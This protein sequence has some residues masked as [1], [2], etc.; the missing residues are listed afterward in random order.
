MLTPPSSVASLR[1]YTKSSTVCPKE[2]SSRR[3]RE[4]YDPLPVSVAAVAFT[5]LL[6]LRS[7][8]ITLSHVCTVTTVA[9]RQRSSS[10]P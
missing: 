5:A 4:D 1:A 10:L 6:L 7:H 2:H 9:K 8:A 3:S